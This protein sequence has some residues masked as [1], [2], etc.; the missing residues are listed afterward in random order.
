MEEENEKVK[1]T[2][3][4]KILEATKT[5]NGYRLNLPS[6]GDLR[7]CIY[8][9]EEGY[10][11]ANTSVEHMDYYFWIKL[12]NDG[13]MEFKNDL[14]RR[15]EFSDGKYDPK[16]SDMGVLDECSR[17]LYYVA[18][19]FEGHK[20]LGVSPIEVLDLRYKMMGMALKML[21]YQSVSQVLDGEPDPDVSIMDLNRAVQFIEQYPAFGQYVSKDSSPRMNIT[22]PDDF[23]KEDFQN[24]FKAAKQL[25]EDEES[26]YGSR[27][28]FFSNVRHPMIKSDFCQGMKSKIPPEDWKCYSETI[29]KLAKL[30]LSFNS[31]L[32]PPED[33]MRIIQSVSINQE[34]MDHQI[35]LVTQVPEMDEALAVESYYFIEE[36]KNLR[37]KVQDDLLDGRTRDSNPGKVM[38]QFVDELKLEVEDRKKGIQRRDYYRNVYPYD[39]TRKNKYKDEDPIFGDD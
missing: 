35:S 39:K 30:I 20:K 23:N 9:S 24:Q 14:M 38:R 37:Q 21:G 33:K 11:L 22:I 12:R 13:W 2:Y 26:Y 32:L 18:K 15:T 29:K 10:T 1:V 34:A 25:L 8:E 31:D 6:Q 3:E 27:N 19:Q 4:G 28:E 17:E 36:T 16:T 5:K 7:S